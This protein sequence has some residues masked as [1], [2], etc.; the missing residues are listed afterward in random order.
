MGMRR[1][2]FVLAVA[3]ALIT[4]TTAPAR[5]GG[6]DALARCWVGAPGNANASVVVNQNPAT[7]GYRYQVWPGDVLRVS[8]TGAI[9]PDSWPWTVRYSPN[10][11][12]ELAPGG[13]HW[14]APGLRKFS[15]IGNINDTGQKLALGSDSGCLVYTGP[16]QTFLWL[17]INDDS[18]LDNSG[19]WNAVIRQYW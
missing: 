4:S 16:V 10:G 5:A 15:L 11:A 17:Q 14:P 12:N 18:V 6:S 3:A 19:Q 13:G 8:A 2:S 9:K 7:F 1:F